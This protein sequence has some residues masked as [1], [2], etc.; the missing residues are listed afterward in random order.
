MK[1]HEYKWY[2]YNLY[3][4]CE[5]CGNK[6]P[7]QGV[8]GNPQCSDCGYTMPHTWVEA[9]EFVGLDDLRS[10]KG[11][12]RKLFGQM[13]ANLNIKSMEHISCMHCNG[14]LNVPVTKDGDALC[15]HCSMPLGVARVEGLKD[16]AIYRYGAGGPGGSKKPQ[17]M[18]AVRC[19][20][21]G[22]PL[23]AD[24]T[25]TG[26]TCDSCNTENILPPALRYKVVLDDIYLGVATETFPPAA[27]FEATNGDMLRRILQ[28]NKR[29][30]FTDAELDRLAVKFP[31]D[32]P[33]FHT[34]VS[35]YG[36]TPSDA[37]LNELWAKTTS[38]NMVQNVGSKLKKTDPEKLNRIL[39]FD[40]TFR[41]PAPKQQPKKKG[42]STST[43]VKVI[44]FLL[45]V[46]AITL[47]LTVI[48]PMMAEK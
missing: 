28:K 32:A 2:S 25:K 31:N 6:I 36:Y 22:A 45:V 18:V 16:I 20:A 10:G 43:A 47:W 8:T 46:A 3:V 12:N 11:G 41:P 33:I 13:E 42:K 5:K 27:A 24:P 40:P 34:L 30:S 38:K 4:G 1:Y 26:Y 37:A 17:G 9:M 21:C 7:M 39:E 48:G 44:F 19:A 15:N 35:N 29:S 14:Q 23:K